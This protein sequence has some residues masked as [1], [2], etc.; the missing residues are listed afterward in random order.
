MPLR[1]VAIDE[2]PDII[3]GRAMVIVGRH[4]T[5]DTCLSSLRASRHHCCV[6]LEDTGLLIR[7]LG[8]TNGIRINGQK[9][10]IG[11]LMPG[12]EVLIAHLRYRVEDGPDRQKPVAR[13]PPVGDLISL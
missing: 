10:E 9:V 7:D 12:D 3:V 13:R 1:L 8:S 11:R 6:S 4:P 5:C 2:G